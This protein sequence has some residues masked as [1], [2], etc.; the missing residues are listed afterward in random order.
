MEEGRTK[1]CR[2]RDQREERNAE[3]EV[4]KY[5][6]LLSAEKHRTR[7]S[8]LLSPLAQSAPSLGLAP[9]AKSH[10]GC[11]IETLT[12]S[13]PSAERGRWRGERREDGLIGGEDARRHVCVLFEVI[14]LIE[15]HRDQDTRMCTACH[16]RLKGHSYGGMEEQIRAAATDSSVGFLDESFSCSVFKMSENGDQCFLKPDMMS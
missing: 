6:L 15:C 16:R 9:F 2:F 7:S 13:K 11:R 8:R 4:V 14:D 10:S 3:R 5:F 12:G 1:N